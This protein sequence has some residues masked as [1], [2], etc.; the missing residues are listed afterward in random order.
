M[1]YTGNGVTSQVERR[2][3]PDRLFE[4]HPFKGVFYYWKA[5]CYNVFLFSGNALMKSFI[6]EEFINRLEW[7]TVLSNDR[8]FAQERILISRRFIY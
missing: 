6:G 4:R 8:V 1:G 7:S 3:D 5:A 2:T